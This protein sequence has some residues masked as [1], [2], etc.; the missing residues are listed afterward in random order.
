MVTNTASGVAALA[1]AMMLLAAQ[2]AS[3]ATQY[4]KF[5]TG[6]G[7]YTQAY[8]GA[9]TIYD[10]TKLLNIDC[11]NAGPCSADNI[12]TS[13]VFIVPGPDITATAPSSKVW[14]DFAPP[15]G[16]LGVGTGSPSTSD[17]IAGTDVLTLTFTSQI[18]LTGV[19]TLFDTG[20]TPF[21][22]NFQTPASVAAAASTI[23]FLLSVDGGV[24][25][26]V[27]FLD[28][29]TNALSLLGT[30]FSFK[31]NGS[32]NPDFYVSAI[33]SAPVP[34][35]AALPLLATALV[36]LLRFGRRAKA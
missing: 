1:V 23:T 19:A 21:G 10:A 25:Q 26:S 31:N 5:Y 29:N 3:A 9:G 14:G 18:R 12:Q 11:P 33:A 7:G 20:H 36:G 24:Y 13:L 34:V 35:P 30:S 15:F 27:K 6:H 22:T 8:S 32:A 4:T 2:P 17:Q 16:G 28:A